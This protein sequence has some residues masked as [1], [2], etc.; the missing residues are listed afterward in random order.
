MT[1]SEVSER[2]E[3]EALQ[4]ATSTP[5]LESEEPLNVYKDMMDKLGELLQQAEDIQSAIQRLTTTMTVSEDEI[6]SSSSSLAQTDGDHDTDGEPEQK[7]E[8]GQET[9]SART[10]ILGVFQACLPVLGA[11]IANL[12]MAQELIDS[13]QENFSLAL[14]MEDMGIE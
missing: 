12:S 9:D 14:R 8:P 11:R 2:V 6:Q 10:Q 13:A 3:A 5:S 7:R 4:L 1:F